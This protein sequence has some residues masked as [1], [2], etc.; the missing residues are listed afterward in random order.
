MAGQPLAPGSQVLLYFG[1]PP[2][3]LAVPD[4]TGKTRQEAELLS[5]GLLLHIQGNPEISHSVKVQAQDPAPGTR[6]KPGASVTLYFTDTTV[7][8]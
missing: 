7:R 5:E 1:N 4:F 2:E 6:V 8:E 3:T